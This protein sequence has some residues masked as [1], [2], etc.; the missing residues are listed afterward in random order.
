MSDIFGISNFLFEGDA[1]EQDDSD[2]IVQK[3]YLPVGKPIPDGWRVLTGN[4][5]NSVVYRVAYRYEI[6][7][8]PAAPIT[9]AA[10]A[11]DLLGRAQGG[12]EVRHEIRW[13][14]DAILHGDYK[15]AVNQLQRCIGEDQ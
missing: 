5:T 11:I 15:L 1:F 12:S 10:E 8:E 13:A 14:I 4:S 9:P 7:D 2:I 3:G 6:E